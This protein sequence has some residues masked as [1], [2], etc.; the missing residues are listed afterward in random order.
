MRK[1]VFFLLLILVAAS[2]ALAQGRETFVD[3][4]KVMGYGQVYAE[5]VFPKERDA[6][7]TIGV[8]RLEVLGV[9]DITDKWKMG[10]TVQFKSPVMLKDL[11]MQYTFMPE[12]RVK[13]GQFKTPFGHENQVA[14]FLNPLTTGGSTATVYF[15]GIAMDP[16]YSGTSGR[17]IGI[18]VAGDLWSNIL[19]YRLM[20]LN[21]RGM[22]TRDIKMGKSVAGS[23]YVRP[24][25]G[26][27]LH[28]SYMG[29]KQIAMA[30]A[31]GIDAGELFT[32]H[33]VSV[34]A[35]ANYK[36]VSV[37]AEYM[38]GSDNSIKGMGGY[39]TAAVHLPNR[40][41]LVLATDYLKTNVDNSAALCTAT[42]GV[43]KWFYGNCR[44]QLHYRYS[45][46]T[47]DFA[48]ATKGHNLRAQL[49]FVF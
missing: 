10:I 20:L 24:V 34:G 23:I 7:S 2:T 12:L 28:T 14:P 4:I 49:Q 47:D 6:M 27:A 38:Y 40:Y 21:A 19:S 35:V 36:P 39:L 8:H 25:A 48:F 26:L 1:S 29:G 44:V 15:A 45:M 17:D 30:G 31:K 43:D 13:L 22:N 37:M 16:L 42:L 5:G 3:R 9:A 18:E 41:D 33:R 11:Y 46:P 32:R